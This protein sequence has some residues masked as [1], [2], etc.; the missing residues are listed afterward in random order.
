MPPAAA[1][2]VSKS[3]FDI[4]PDLKNEIIR[5]VTK[6]TM[7]VPKS[8]MIPRQAKQNNE[9]PMK[10]YRFFLLKSSSKVA[11]P[12]QMKAIFTSSDGWNEKPPISSQ[13]FA[14]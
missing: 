12:T 8:P 10:I 2:P 13:F 14:P 5:K 4:S 9:K 3:S 1:T 11:A 7:A 6:N